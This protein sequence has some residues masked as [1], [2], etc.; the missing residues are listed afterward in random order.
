LA[1][2]WHFLGILEFV[3]SRKPAEIELLAAAFLSD[4][5]D[6]LA[7]ANLRLPDVET[8]LI[9]AL[10]EKAR[11][12]D[13][14]TQF[15]QALQSEFEACSDEIA[16]IPA[17]LDKAQCAACGAARFTPST[18]LLAYILP[19]AELADE[20]G[21]WED[22]PTLDRLASGAG[23]SSLVRSWFVSLSFLEA[24]SE[25]RFQS[26]IAEHR[27]DIRAMLT[28][29]ADRLER[30]EILAP[31]I[32]LNPDEVW[33]LLFASRH[34]SLISIVHSP[35]RRLV[36]RFLRWQT[37]EGWWAND[38]QNRPGH[39]LTVVILYGVAVFGD[40]LDGT[41]RNGL[42]AGLRWL[43]ASQGTNGGWRI[44]EDDG[45]AEGDVLT[46]ALAV[47]LLRRADEESFVG[48]IERGEAYLLGRQTS[49]GFWTF[50]SDPVGLMPVVLECLGR[51]L[52]PI[53]QREGL[54]NLARDLMFK[55]E[56]LAR[57]NDQVDIQLCV[58]AAHHAA[59]LFTYGVLTA[60]DPPVSFTRN[61][62]K[63]VG[64]REALGLL[65]TRLRQDGELAA[66]QGLPLRDQVQ[67]LANLRDAIV[68]QGQI[69][70]A[71]QARAQIVHA[72]RYLERQSQARLGH[73][74]LR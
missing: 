44:S 39:F 60:F 46:T 58:I 57:S 63:T 61:D 65:E 10:R 32:N 8:A 48:E 72:R 74:I 40:Q 35:T 70:S 36:H 66:N 16:T 19:R 56:E 51:D 22:R 71:E 24:V 43:A 21:A 30:A 53:Q 6:K 38:H 13:A 62:G 20:V 55:S 2:L 31:G 12:V 73:D 64:L 45:D 37:N 1:S 14:E 11:D 54:L 25:R 28:E 59:E 50:P 41:V 23:Y 49:V 69:V 3:A 68:H 47:D 18:E 4:H 67:L 17:S 7:A 26:E 5:G 15:H 29:A 42:R 9:E 27:V 33:C 34:Q 52:P